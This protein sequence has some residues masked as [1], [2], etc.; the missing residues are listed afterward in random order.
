MRV[1][2]ATHLVAVDDDR[3][4]RLTADLAHL[5]AVAGVDPDRLGGDA[6][7]REGE[8]HPLGVRRMRD[9]IEPEHGCRRGFRGVDSRTSGHMLAESP[10]GP[11]SATV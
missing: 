11:A 4:E 7:V 2:S 8:R 9:A 10:D 6:L 5:G 1:E 3:Y